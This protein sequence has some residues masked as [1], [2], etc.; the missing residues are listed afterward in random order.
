LG[1]QLN[2]DALREGVKIGHR[3]ANPVWRLKDGSLAEW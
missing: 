2:E 1:V 3:W